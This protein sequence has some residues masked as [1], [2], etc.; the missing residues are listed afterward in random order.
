MSTAQQMF[1]FRLRG[2]A[3]TSTTS[4]IIAKAV[5][6][7]VAHGI[8]L[9]GGPQNLAIG[10]CLFEIIIDSINIRHS[11]KETLDGSPD[12]WRNLWLGQVEEVAYE[13]WNSGL[14]A[15]EW[16]AG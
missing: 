15:A 1:P 8:K 14:S 16:K 12:Y 13:K 7:G 9:H 2:G 5:A 6:N 10:N 4:P 11:F 3:N